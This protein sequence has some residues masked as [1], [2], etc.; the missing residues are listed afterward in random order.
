[1][2]TRYKALRVTNPKG[3]QSSTYFLQLPY[4]YSVPLLAISILLHWVLSGCIYILVTEGGYYQN[5]F[6]SDGH[7]GPFGSYMAVGF[8]TKSIFTMMVLSISLAFTPSL[9]GLIRLPPTTVVV[10]SN[11][12]AIAAAC[13]VSP[14]VGEKQHQSWRTHRDSTATPTDDEVESHQ[15]TES[16]TRLLSRGGEATVSRDAEK[17]LKVTL[18]RASQSKIRWGVV[19]VPPSWEDQ[20]HMPGTTVEHLS[21]GLEEDDVQ[22][23]IVGHCYA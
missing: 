14:L 22:E 19:A 10:G 2:A 3:Q 12:L 18:L 7:S 11:S 6:S 4:R 13:Q 8:S 23:P 21:F 5:L 16:S 17:E 20:F 9:F 15:L 1:M